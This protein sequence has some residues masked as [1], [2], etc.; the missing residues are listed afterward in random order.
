MDDKKNKQL[1]GEDQVRVQSQGTTCTTMM[2]VD[3]GVH[4][5]MLDA[6]NSKQTSLFADLEDANN[7]RDIT[8]TKPEITL[9]NEMNGDFWQLAEVISVLLFTHSETSDQSSQRYYKGDGLSC[10]KDTMV[11]F[12]GEKD[13]QQALIKTSLMEMAKIKQGNVGKVGGKD[14]TAMKDLVMRYSDKPYKVKYRDYY[15]VTK[16]GKQKTEKREYNE[17]FNLYH[18]VVIEDTGLKKSIVKLLLHPIWF[19]LVKEHCYKKPVD[20]LQRAKCAYK[21][22]SGSSRMPDYLLPWLN[23][24]VRAQLYPDRTY[25][26]KTISNGSGMFEKISPSWVK[27]RMWKQLDDTLAVFVE[28]AKRIG[29]LEEYTRTNSKTGGGEVLSFKVIKQENLK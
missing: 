26:C 9:E 3:T 14:I 7:P 16:D 23:E 18:A 1:R 20:F 5:A 10:T 19:R 11:E 28:V 21:E 2:R 8:P 25:H 15:Q 27:K 4:N 29:L 22:I 17:K 24:L 12:C 13:V 6:W